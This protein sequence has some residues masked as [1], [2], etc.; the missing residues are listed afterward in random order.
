MTAISS[1][2]FVAGM[3]FMLTGALSKLRAPYHIRDSAEADKAI[4]AA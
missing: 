4:Q 2:S 3:A 1:V